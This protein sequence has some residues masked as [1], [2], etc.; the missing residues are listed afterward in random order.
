MSA[1]PFCPN[2]SAV[3]AR[4]DNGTGYV[5]RTRCKQWNCEYCAAINARV[6]QWR[7]IEEVERHP[8]DGWHFWTFTLL[9][10]DHV[11][12]AHSMQVWRGVW[13]KLMQRIKRKATLTRYIRLFET[14]ADGTFHV[15][16]LA[17][18]TF[19]DTKCVVESDGRENWRSA[20][21]TAILN[22]LGLGWRHD[23]RPLRSKRP[24]LY[25][26]AMTIA[27]Y[28]AKYLTKAGQSHVRQVLRDAG[29][30]RV[31]IL[32]ASHGWAQMEKTTSD[33]DWR[34]GAVGKIE[35]NT[36]NSL[37][38]VNEQR[39]VEPTEFELGAYPNKTWDM[40]NYEE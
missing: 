21:M 10:Q 1:M 33:L 20:T 29:M 37:F 17:N 15:H 30:G 32:Q 28:V 3:K 23:I 35:Y 39:N 2:Y 22:E 25:T 5:Y 13:Q 11:G 26:D 36:L 9:G 18:A 4:D 34:L 14:H 7:I 31:R 16:M 38:D 19:T 8:G 6:W 24:D 27:N 12:A 40:A